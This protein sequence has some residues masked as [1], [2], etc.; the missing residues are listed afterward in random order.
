MGEPITIDNARD[1]QQAS[2]EVRRTKANPDNLAFAT[3]VKAMRSGD[4]R[5]ALQWLIETGAIKRIAKRDRD[6]SVADALALLNPIAA[7][8]SRPGDHPSTQKPPVGG[9][10]DI[11][12][13]TNFSGS[14]SQPV[15]NTRVRPADAPVYEPPPSPYGKPGILDDDTIRRIRAHGSSWRDKK[16]RSRRKEADDEQD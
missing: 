1:R 2:L 8:P 3:I 15:D 13:Q 14:A 12:S 6:E 16:R 4:A 5:I 7:E 9:D 10:S 11:S